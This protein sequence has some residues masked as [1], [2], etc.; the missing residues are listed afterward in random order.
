MFLPDHPR[1][2][3]LQPPLACC[4]DL[5]S[6][7]QPRCI[8]LAAN[9]QFLASPQYVNPHPLYTLRLIQ[10]TNL[11][12]SFHFPQSPP[13]SLFPRHHTD[14]FSLSE[15]TQWPVWSIASA[16]SINDARESSGAGHTNFT[17]KYVD[18]NRAISAAYQASLVSLC[19]PRASTPSYLS[20][21]QVQFEH[22]DLSFPELKSVLLQSPHFLRLLVDC[23]LCRNH[24]SSNIYF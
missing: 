24:L 15:W 17:I 1:C 6:N 5:S 13:F 12:P 3:V 14:M 8:C 16:L 4:L 20:F 18:S 10:K 11:C 7:T 22:L 21:T 19:M 9:S 2:P 23:L